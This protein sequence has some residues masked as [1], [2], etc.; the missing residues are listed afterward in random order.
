MPIGTATFVTGARPDVEAAYTATPAANRAGWGYLLLTNMLPGG[1]N[2]TFRLTAI[3][4]DAEG[5][6]TTL[7]SKTIVVN[8]ASATAPF[9][10]IDTP[11]QGATISGNGYTNFGWA[12]TPQPKLIPFSGATINVFIDG[13]PIGAVTQYNLFQSD[14]SNLFPNLKNSGGPVGFKTIDTTA[15]G[16][17]VHTIAWVATDDAG[18]GTGIGSRYFTV[19][20]SAW[21]P[22]ITQ[23]PDAP[24]EPEAISVPPRIAGPDLGRRS[25]NLSLLP[26]ADAE[27]SLRRDRDGGIRRSSKPASPGDGP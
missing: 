11:A 22:S 26:A 10:A 2:G 21:Q 20:N 14:V 5:G 25:A 16:E 27:V 17:G 9:G 8:N 23:A 12:L 13:A 3:A 6:S 4:E 1:G 18:V 15:L 7:G 24:A 19:N